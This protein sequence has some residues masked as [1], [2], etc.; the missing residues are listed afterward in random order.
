MAGGE[1]VAPPVWVQVW[2]AGCLTEPLEA[3]LDAV[4]G[5]G[6][7]A[8]LGQPQLRQ[9]GAL[10]LAPGPQIAAQRPRGLGPEPDPSVL[11]ALA[12]EVHRLGVQV[13]IGH[14]EVA[15][16]G[17]PGTGVAVQPNQRLVP[18]VGE[19]LALARV[20]ELAGVL[21]AQNRDQLPGY[22]RLPNPFHRRAVDG[23]LVDEQPLEELLQ[24]LVLVQRG[25]RRP[26]V[27]HP[28]LERLHV[29]PGHRTRVVSRAIGVR[30]R[31]RLPQIPTQL[32]GSEEVVVA[33]GLRVVPRP[34]R[35]VPVPK[36]PGPGP[37]Q[38]G[39]ELLKIPAVA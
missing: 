16:L 27:D 30:I 10:V 12:A 24:P 37:G 25:R 33:G 31:G 4:R 8:A 23:L 3:D 17:Q 29:R 13:D 32:S 14:E 2:H 28:G 1:G 36:E 22:L 18:Q 35:P 20:E 39:G 15:N 9:C 21:V 5:Q 6:G 11:R 26:G 7:H 19:A 38:S 34:Q